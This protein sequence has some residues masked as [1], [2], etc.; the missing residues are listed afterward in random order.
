M[1]DTDKLFSSMKNC[2]G[3]FENFSFS[4]HCMGC[5]IKHECEAK[6]KEETNEQS[7]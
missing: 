3:M 1:S 6:A 7:K 2:F 5:P 4:W